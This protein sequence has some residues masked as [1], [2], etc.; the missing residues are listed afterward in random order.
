MNERGWRDEDRI[1]KTTQKE[2]RIE[3]DK[4]KEEIMK[5]KNGEVQT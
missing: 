3:K 5:G 2:K 1:H 4:K